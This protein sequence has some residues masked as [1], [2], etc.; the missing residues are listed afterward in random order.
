VLVSTVYAPE[1]EIID[2]C[3]Y[4]KLLRFLMPFTYR[5]VF[6]R[7]RFDGFTDPPDDLEN[8]S[9]L[10]RLTQRLLAEGYSNALRVLRQ[11]WGK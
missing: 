1:R 6:C 3:I 4:L 5:K 10:P 9:Q 8:G 11:E 7:D 2:D